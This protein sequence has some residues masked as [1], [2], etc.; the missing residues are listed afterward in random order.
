M[1]DLFGVTYNKPKPKPR[2]LFDDY[3]SFIKKFEI[4]KTTD[5]CYTPPR[6]YDAIVEYV[7]SRYN[8]DGKRI[9]RPFYPGGDYE[10]ADY[11]LS[12]VVIDNPPF[13]ILARIVKY[14]YARKVPFFLF[15]PTLTLLNSTPE[16]VTAI[17]V[18]AS[19]TYE[20]G[21]NVN[22]SFLTNMWGE[23]AVE[24]SGSLNKML[25]ALNPPKAQLAKYQYPD[26]VI[27]AALL[28]K[29][30]KRGIDVAFKA[31][32][33][34]RIKKLDFAKDIYGGGY[35]L[36]TSAAAEKAAAEKAAAEKAAAEK[37]VK[38]CLSPRELRIIEELDNNEDG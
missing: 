4:K 37:A 29:I 14:Y 3:D 7:G 22:T 26:N 8:L 16:G 10:G 31:S 11:G 28:A 13:S 18:G 27:S 2:R 24:V 23:G 25:E 19:I 21:A 30:A 5:D 12:D 17:V 6:V 20:N 1:E 32:S 33:F 35:L 15:A 9:V 38:I 36:S 34:C